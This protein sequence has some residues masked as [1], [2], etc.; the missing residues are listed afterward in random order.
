MT[1]S[2]RIGHFTGLPPCFVTLVLLLLLQLEVVQLGSQSVLS[3][4][5]MG[6]ERWREV[7]FERC[8]KQ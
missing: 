8:W 2:G 7:R 6:C 3:S 5:T 4:L 1:E